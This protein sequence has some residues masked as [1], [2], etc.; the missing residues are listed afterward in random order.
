MNVIWTIIILFSFCFSLYSNNT[1]TLI[2]SIFLV[3]KDSLQLLLN[4]GSLIVIYNGIFQIALDAQLIKQVSKVF[5]KI[6]KKIFNNLD[7]ETEDLVCANICANILGLGVATTP[8]ALE[9]MA[10]I[11]HSD[12]IN[13][14]ILCLIGIN[15]CSFTFFPLTPLTIRNSVNGSYNALIWIIITIISFITS[16]LAIL[17]GKKWRFNDLSNK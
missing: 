3:P 16:V 2:N 5:K 9:I 11:N 12:K 15:V 13:N 14:N 17:I 7:E 1:N 10:K 4:I 6:V 8:I